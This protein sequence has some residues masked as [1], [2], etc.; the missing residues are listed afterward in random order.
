MRRPG[1][2]QHAVRLARREQFGREAEG[3]CGRHIVVREAVDEQQRAAQQVSVSDQR[4]ACVVLRLL[5]RVAQVP[6]L[7]M[8][9]VE[10]LIGGRGAGDGR[11]EDIGT[12]EYGGRRQETAERPAADR[13]APQVEVA[14]PVACGQQSVHLILQGGRE[15]VAVDGLFPG[16]AAP[17]SPAPVDHENREALLGEPLGHAENHPRARTASCMAGPP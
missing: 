3:V 15:L 10:P 7:P 14:E 1:Q 8:S 9:V 17:G 4:R 13:H 12:V 5:V 2:W 16:G 6:L 11:V